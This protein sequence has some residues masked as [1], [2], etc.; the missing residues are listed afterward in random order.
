[1][2][3]L[4]AT[5][6]ILS[7]SI[8]ALTPSY[9]RTTMMQPH[10]L[11]SLFPLLLWSSIAG[12]CGALRGL[13]FTQLNQRMYDHLSTSLFDRIRT[14]TMETWDV[15]WKESELTRTILTD[16]YEVIQAVSLFC[17]VSLRTLTTILCVSLQ[18]YALSPSLFYHGVL[19]SSLQVL[20]FHFV[21][22]HF[23]KTS[24]ESTK[25]KQEAEA[26]MNEFVQKHGSILLYGW[27]DMYQVSHQQRMHSYQTATTA[28]SYAYATLLL[29]SQMLPGW[30][31]TY[32]ILYMLHLGYPI[33]FL[34]EVTA[35]YHLMNSALQACKEQW[36]A[37]WKKKEAMKMLWGILEKPSAPLPFSSTMYYMQRMQ[38]NQSNPLSIEW[39]KLT[40][41][42]PM[43]SIPVFSSFSLRIE[44]GQHVILSAKSGKG[45]T[46]LLT[47][48]MGLYPVESGSI[49]IGPYHIRELQPKEIRSFISIVPQDP[50]YDPHR[51]LREN[52]L[53][54]LPST[55]V[56]PDDL[57]EKVH[58]TE[59]KDRLDQRIVN[60]SGGQKQR[61]AVA[62]IL[63][64]DT[65]IVILDEP[66]SALDAEVEQEMIALIVEHVKEK[67]VVWITHHVEMLPSNMKVIPF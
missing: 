20:L 19:I 65:P 6:G 53:M 15:E 34:L 16:I 28:E 42:Y 3:L 54:G 22:P 60:V 39:S 33:S 58:L 21:Q 50:W 11:S 46:T 23:Q 38:H 48:L 29:T 18:W 14:A 57:L 62:R 61:I 51:T 25:K 2:Y 49:W 64:R 31:E 10:P 41:R 24:D 9:L 26:N 44:A 47:L 55:C 32:L 13:L 17:N 37:S 45:K 27:Q 36:V 30:G 43:S 12:I 1:M 67:T 66:T 7:S 59:L 35:Y 52:L 8:G 4:A 40:F 63:L 5:I 56:L